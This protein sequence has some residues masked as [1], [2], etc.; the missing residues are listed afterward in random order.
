[1]VRLGLAVVWYLIL[2]SLGLL[3]FGRCC[4]GG[5][6]FG[7]LL[8]F[9]WYTVALEVCSVVGFLV[10]CW[11]LV[12]CGLCV[13]S[14]VVVFVY[15]VLFLFVCLFWVVID[16]AVLGCCYLVICCGLLVVYFDSWCLSVG[17][18]VLDYCGRCIV[19]A[20]LGVCAVDFGGFAVVIFIVV[21]C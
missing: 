1:M 17:L 20:I 13:N 14:V 15:V 4:F 21:V 7:D 19:V 12:V 5:F 8:W 9:G 18:W 11:L 2:F 10:G 16:L 6:V 3:G